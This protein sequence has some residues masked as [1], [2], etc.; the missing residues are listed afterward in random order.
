[1]QGMDGLTSSSRRISIS[2]H[3]RDQEFARQGDDRDATGS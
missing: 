1:M 3:G 2:V